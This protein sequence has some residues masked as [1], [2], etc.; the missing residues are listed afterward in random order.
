MSQ[1]Q[2]PH[3]LVGTQ[4]CPS[5]VRRIQGIMESSLLLCSALETTP[6]I[7]HFATEASERTACA[8]SLTEFVM[9]TVPLSFGFNPFFCRHQ[10]NESNE[11]PAHLAT[12]LAFTPVS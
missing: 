12:I 9:N 4:I 7:S 1:H 8:Q 11:W 10:A 2:A 3:S 6:S 5:N